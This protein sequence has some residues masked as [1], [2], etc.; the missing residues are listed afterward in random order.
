MPSLNRVSLSRLGE[1]V[2]EGRV[3]VSH[4][5]EDWLEAQSR[6]GLQVIEARFDILLAK[7]AQQQVNAVLSALNSGIGIS[8]AII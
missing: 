2:T 8:S 6:K 4:R 1:R 7:R 5:A 3:R